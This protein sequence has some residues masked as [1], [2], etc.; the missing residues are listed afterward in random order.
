MAKRV[1]IYKITCLVNGKV[2]I[3]RTVKQTHKRLREHFS[4][5]KYV[6]N[7][8][9]LYVDMKKYGREQFCVETVCEF[10]ADSF[11]AADTVEL[12]FIEKHNAFYPN[13]Y[14]KRRVAC[15]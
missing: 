4:E 10:F 6:K 14:N 13:G 8:K 15:G 9:P 7:N 12:S 3:G 5:S 1:Y 2:Y 11:E